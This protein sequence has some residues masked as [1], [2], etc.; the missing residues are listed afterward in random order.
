MATLS[1]T[2][3]NTGAVVSTGIE[4]QREDLQ[5]LPDMSSALDCPACGRRH[6]WRPSEAWLAGASPEARSPET[7]SFSHGQ[8]KRMSV[9]IAFGNLPATT[10]L[11]AARTPA[12]GPSSPHRLHHSPAIGR[13]PLRAEQSLA[14]VRPPPVV[15][16]H[17]P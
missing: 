16:P 14:L 17:R 10:R 13:L 15:Y 11:K 3:P 2:C 1:I 5:R 4:I 9:P 12:S 6:G 8:W 7:S